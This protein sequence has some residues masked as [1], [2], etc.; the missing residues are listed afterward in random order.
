MAKLRERDKKS[1]PQFE[2]RIIKWVHPEDENTTHYARVAGCDYH[3]GVTLVE[4]ANPNHRLSCFNGP[5]SADGMRKM[6]DV[7]NYLEKY[8]VN[9][10]YFLDVMRSNGVYNVQERKENLK[11]AGYQVPSPSGRMASCSFGG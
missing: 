1:Y 5:S 11:K 4:D 2:G 6:E 9:F 7:E 8:D 10:K 3:I